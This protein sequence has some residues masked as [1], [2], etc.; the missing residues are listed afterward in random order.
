MIDPGFPP[1]KISLNSSPPLIGTL[2]KAECEHA[3]ACL[4]RCYQVKGNWEPIT[5][6]EFY[7]MA[8]EAPGPLEVWFPN[9]LFKPDFKALVKEG[10]AVQVYDGYDLTSVGL[11]K[12]AKWRLP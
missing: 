10:Y 6:Q 11:E 5:H 9:P 4:I 2:G 8:R 1:S 12:L 7:L 3:A